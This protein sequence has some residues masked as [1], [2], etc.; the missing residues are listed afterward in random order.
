[1]HSPNEN[2]PLPDLE[3]H[4]HSILLRENDTKGGGGLLLASKKPSQTKD[5]QAFK[6]SALR[7]ITPT[8]D[9]SIQGKQSLPKE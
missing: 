1:M 7:V 6:G 5:D 2:S 8:S 9:Q 3:I 4:P